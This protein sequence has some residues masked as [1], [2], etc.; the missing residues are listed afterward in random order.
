MDV[1]GVFKLMVIF[2]DIGIGVVAGEVSKGSICV[3]CV[4]CVGV[5]CVGCAG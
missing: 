4:G 5:G 3:G 2:G 1:G